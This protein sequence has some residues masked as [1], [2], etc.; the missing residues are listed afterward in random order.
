MKTIASKLTEFIPNKASP[1]RYIINLA[2][3]PVPAIKSAPCD[4]HFKNLQ[5]VFSSKINYESLRISERNDFKI[6]FNYSCEE[7][8]GY[9][10]IIYASKCIGTSTPDILNKNLLQTK[11][12]WKIKSGAVIP[13]KVKSWVISDTAEV[14]SFRTFSNPWSVAKEKWLMISSLENVWIINW[15][16]SNPIW[17][18]SS[19]F[20]ILPS[21]MSLQLDNFWCCNKAV[22]D[23]LLNVFVGKEQQKKYSFKKIKFESNH[24]WGKIKEHISEKVIFYSKLKELYTIHGD[25]W[26]RLIRDFDISKI[27]QDF[28]S[29]QN[30]TSELA[31]SENIQEFN[32]QNIPKVKLKIN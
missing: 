23:E 19:L 20:N 10:I 13:E 6:D 15:K 26:I 11:S 7:L 8:I 30:F 4:K 16:L 27:S 5:K 28:N 1:E 22:L 24:I 31:W 17:A 21:D 3:L 18:S 9:S 2:P 29:K 32:S 14:I 12:T 25:N